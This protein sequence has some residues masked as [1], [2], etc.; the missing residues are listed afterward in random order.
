LFRKELDTYKLETLKNERESGCFLE[1][2]GSVL[3]QTMDIE[4]RLTA[5]HKTG[6]SKDEFI[7]RELL[8]LHKFV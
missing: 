8:R 1:Q 7:S 4:K 5:L 3:Q 6:I 2:V